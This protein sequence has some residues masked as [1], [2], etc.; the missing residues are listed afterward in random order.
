L[1]RFIR[2]TRASPT[3]SLFTATLGKHAPPL[4]TCV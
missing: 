4:P 2:K 1:A 3:V